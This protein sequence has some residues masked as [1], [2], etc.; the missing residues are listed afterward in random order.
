MSLGIDWDL[1][2]IIAILSI[3]VPLAAFGWEFGVVGRKR[4]GYRVQMD[5]LATDTAHSPYAGVLRELH[6]DHG[7]TLTNPSFVLLRIENAGWQP[8]VEGDYLTSESDKTGIR[9]TFQYRRVAG[10]VVT[11]P[12]Q[13]E[14]RDFFTEE[15]GG[16]GYGEENGAGLIRLPKVKLNRRAHYKVLAVLESTSGDQREDFPDPVF[17]ADVSGGNGRG[18]LARFV[19]FKM[20]KTESHRFA[21][22]P[23][24][25]FVTLLALGV[26]IQAATLT[27]A[28]EP[29]PRDCVGGT[30]YLH[31]STA[32][33][34]AVRKAAAAYTDR[35]RRAEVRIPVTADTFNG[36]TEGLNDLERV[37]EDAG[38]EPG[39]GLADHIAFSDGKALGNH[40][41]LLSRP[42]AYLPY[43][44]VVNADADV[45]DLTR[46]QIR[47]I[48]TGKVKRWSDVG[49]ADIP[50]HLVNRH[51]GSGTRTALVER[52]LGG[53]EPV[54]P[55]VSDCTALTPATWGACEVGK[56]STLVDMTAD[57]PGAIG[58]SEVSS[59]E[60]EDGVVLL[61]IDGQEPTLTGVEQGDYPYWETEYA[62]TYGRAP[63]GSLAQA[64][65][66]FLTVEAGR[67]T[68]GPYARLCSEVDKPGLCEPT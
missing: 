24:W 17:R 39:E 22:R 48:Y 12:S 51:R 37:G 42:L 33:E 59:A 66:S 43:T 35:C 30:L 55:T 29:A 10:A 1:D 16:F 36:S 58:Y 31:G 27:F 9:V 32:F 4:L 56:T 47:D 2:T 13:P 28:P 3:V 53:K 65:L 63:D 14:L 21:S 7:S 41:R 61:R 62:Y 68:L 44:L 50:V 54:A 5:T 45:E 23:G 19:K 15:V 38:I 57:I 26:L 6:D 40:P 46:E 20:S 52:V 8:I 34:P 49:G 11:E 67:E 25:V 60:R 18:L 64:F